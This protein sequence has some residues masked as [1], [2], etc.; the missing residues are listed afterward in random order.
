MVEST[1]VVATEPPK[2]DVAVV[3]GEEIAP[4]LLVTVKGEL[5]FLVPEPKIEPVPVE[6]APK[7][8]VEIGVVLLSL[9]GVPKIDPL[10]RGCP[11][12]PNGEAPPKGVEGVGFVAICSGFEDLF[13]MLVTGVGAGLDTSDGF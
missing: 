7:K 8:D 13:S 3:A 4:P 1:P 10:L 11:P 9:E 6:D 2:I 12:P 5:S